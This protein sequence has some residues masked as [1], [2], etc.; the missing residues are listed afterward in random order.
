M[1]ASSS[2]GNRPTFVP[3]QGGHDEKQSEESPK[4]DV[5][6]SDQNGMYQSRTAL[7]AT[8]VKQK[9]EGCTLATNFE[10]TINASTKVARAYKDDVS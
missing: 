5:W 3:F 1:F 4:E 2:T 6:N 7:L 8:C 10:Q 9:H